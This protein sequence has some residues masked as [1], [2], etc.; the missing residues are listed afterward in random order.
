MYTSGLG[1]TTTTSRRPWPAAEAAELVKIAAQED[2]LTKP[3]R[4]ISTANFS[5]RAWQVRTRQHT[6]DDREAEAR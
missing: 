6:R 3:R 2:I 1:T 4:P 5:L